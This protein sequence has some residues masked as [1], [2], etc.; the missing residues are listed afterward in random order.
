MGKILDMKAIILAAGRGSRLHPYTAECPK[1]LTELGGQSL[2][3]RQ[4][5]VLR[6]AGIEDIII[7]TGYR[8]DMLRLVGTR[9]VHN[10]R[11]ESTN[12]VESLFCAKEEFGEDLIVS[13][14]DIVYEERILQALLASD[15]EVEVAVDHKWR[16]Y[17]EWRF[18][19]P[20]SDAE[21]LRLD[22]E[23]RILDIGGEVRKIQEIEAQYM[24]LMRFRGGGVEQ[25]KKARGHM[26]NADRAWK[27]SRPV[28]KAYMTDLL[29]EMVLMG[30]EVWSVQ[31]EGGWLEVDTVEDYERL[32]PLFED[33]GIK[34]FYDPG[35]QF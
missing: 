8:R 4:L 12:M 7:V 29:M 30:F 34:R 20:L 21:S 31:I 1:C 22:A 26:Q 15:R 2:I 33:G 6:S 25:L 28:E 32:S 5:S 19:D 23:G 13:Y 17:W 24:G 27:A 35:I 16:D 14:S 9:E 3:S 11:W 18:D 10:E